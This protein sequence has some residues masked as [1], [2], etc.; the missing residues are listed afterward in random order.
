MLKEL[1]FPYNFFSGNREKLLAKIAD[2]SVIFILSNL[3]QIRNGD[4]EFD[5]RQDSNFFYYTGLELERAVLAL[6][7]FKGQF[8]VK[9]FYKKREA[10]LEKWIGKD[11]SDEE[12]YKISKIKEICQMEQITSFYSYCFDDLNI[13]NVYLYNAKH[14]S[15]VL[16]TYTQIFALNIK[17]QYP[18]IVFKSLNRIVDLQRMKKSKFEIKMLRRAVK[19][20]EIGLKNL[21]EKIEIGVNERE[22]E[23]LL[24]YHYQRNNCRCGFKT[25]I[26]SGRNASLIHY[27]D[28]NAKLRENDLLLI[29]TGAEYHNYTADVSRTY[30]VKG[31]FSPAK[32]DLY[33]MVLDVQ[34][35]VMSLIKPGV[36]FAE[37]EEKAKN[38]LYRG[39]KSLKYISYKQELDRYYFHS[40]GHF[41][42]LDVHDVGSKELPLEKG[43]VITI[44]PGIYI[45]EKSLGIRIEDDLLVYDQGYEVLTKNIP[46][47][48]TEIEEI[49]KK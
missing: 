12:I 39:L 25:I 4:V 27:E 46:K 9:L 3:K 35:Q 29:D 30:P 42:G 38:E 28:N 22:Y 37:L 8:E 44:E 13:K 40:I 7:K 31:K 20:T 43:H 47:K 19:I 11:P 36:L 41:L 2:N 10:D 23:A 26:A 16:P 14:I 34:K 48:I 15:K 1:K 21:L 33:Q 45:P 49:M 18:K 5:F 6:V 17:N 32:R 24:S